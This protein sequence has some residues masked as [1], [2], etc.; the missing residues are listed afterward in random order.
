[1]KRFQV[2]GIF[3][4][5]LFVLIVLS[6]ALGLAQDKFVTL[7]FSSFFTPSHELAKITDQWCKE[8]EKR[9][10]GRVKARH[11]P[12][13]TMN[14]APVMYDSVVQGV[15]DVGNHVLGYTMGKF[16]LAEVLDYPLG[17]PSGYVATKLVN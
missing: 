9:T 4:A 8:V 11:Y 3:M 1:M 2:T 12:G 5:A 10:N 6:S 17:Y 15:I 7:R 16:P 14:S 13:G